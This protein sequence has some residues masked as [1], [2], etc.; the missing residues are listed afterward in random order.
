MQT[1]PELVGVLVAGYGLDEA[2][3][4]QIRKLTHSEIAFLVQGPG[5]EARLAVSSLG[6]REG[7]L[8]AAVSRP[9][10]ARANGTPFEIDLDHFQRLLCLECYCR[11]CLHRTLASALL[12]PQ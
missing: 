12:P 9:Q 3:A 10:L 11:T 1:G 5:Q 2:V 6:R 8:A 4:L 7:A